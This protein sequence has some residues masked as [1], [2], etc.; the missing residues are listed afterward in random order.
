MAIRVVADP[1]RLSW[2]NFRPVGEIP[3]SSEEAQIAPDIHFPRMSVQNRNG[4]A[5][6]GDFTI[7]V[8][9]RREDTLIVRTARKT[10]ELLEHEQGHFDLLVLG[11]R[12]MARELESLE[13]DSPAELQEALEKLKE[14]HQERATAIDE[15]YDKQ[16]AHSR[17]AIQ[18]RRWRQMI[19]DAA[20]NKASQIDGMDL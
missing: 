20:A 12:Q 17:N 5:R 3:G 1:A 18:Q 9:P 2:R 11:A 13:A 6:L 16:T 4:K 10:P 7:T 19:A 15:A 8:R 14:T